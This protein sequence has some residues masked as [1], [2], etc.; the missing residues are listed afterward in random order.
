MVK[1]TANLE[2]LLTLRA[3][4][5]PPWEGINPG[6]VGGATTAIGPAGNNNNN[7]NNNNNRVNRAIATTLPAGGKTGEGEG[8]GGGYVLGGLGGLASSS[9]SLRSLFPPRAINSGASGVGG[10]SVGA[11]SLSVPSARGQGLGPHLHHPAVTSRGG[12]STH[13]QTQ[14]HSTPP[15]NT[16][17]KTTPTRSPNTPTSNTFPATTTSTATTTGALTPVVNLPTRSQRVETSSALLSS[18]ESSQRRQVE[19]CEDKTLPTTSHYYVILTSHYHNYP[20]PHHATYSSH[21]LLY[22][23]FLLTLLCTYSP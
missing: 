3:H 17:N 16:T 23:S 12:K 9:S 14:T 4:V 13:T 1:Y 19:S 22:I 2:H 5:T 6:A 15:K 18:P 8:S 7:N 11:R 10:A 20:T 21:S